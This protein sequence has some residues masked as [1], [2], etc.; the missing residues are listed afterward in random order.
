MKRQSATYLYILLLLHILLPLAVEAQETSYTDS[1]RY[2][3]VGGTGEG[4]SWTDAYG[5]LQ[6][7]INDLHDHLEEG[8]GRIY[9]A[10]GAY[11]PTET[12]EGI[13]SIVNNTRFTSFKIY[14]GITIYG[15]FAADI[16][17]EPGATA[18]TVLNLPNTRIM[19]DGT[20]TSTYAEWKNEKWNFAH[21]T[22]LSGEHS[23]APT[24][25]WDA[26]GGTYNTNLEGCSYHVIWFATNGFI[27]TGETPN[28]VTTNYAKPLKQTSE[29]NGVTIKHG[30]ANGA[31][32]YAH[33]YKGGGVYMVGNS[34]LINCIVSRCEANN[35]GGGIYMDGG[36]Y[37][38]NCFVHTNQALGKETSEDDGTNSY[39]GGICIDYDGTVIR[40]IMTNN[41]AQRGGG[42]AILHE[43]G[44][45][46][47]SNIGESNHKSFLSPSAAG[48]V[49]S[50]NTSIH[51]AGGVL[52]KEGGNINHMTITNNRCN[53]KNLII[54]GRRIGRSGGIYIDKCGVVFNSVCWGNS[55]D[56]NDIQY[57]AYTANST[58][59][60]SPWVYFSAFSRHDL[61]D[62]HGTV[63]DNVLSISPENSNTTV[64]GLYPEF[65][66]PTSVAGVSITDKGEPALC[67]W[68]PHAYS[69][70]RGQG[71][72]L[73]DFITVKDMLAAEIKQDMRSNTFA[74]RTTLGAYFP[75]KDKRQPVEIP[76]VNGSGEN[77]KTLFVDPQRKYKAS[78]NLDDQ[79][80]GDSWDS[81]LGNLNDALNFIEEERKTNSE[82]SEGKWQILVKEGELTT[83]GNYVTGS[84][85]SSSII[86]QSNVSIYGG[87]PKGLTGTNLSSGVLE[88]NPVEY[89]TILTG[90][91]TGHNYNRNAHHLV[92]FNEVSNAILDGFKLYY[93]NAYTE[94][95]N[96]ARS[97]H[98][99]GVIVYSETEGVSMEGNVMRNCVI[100]N[101]TGDEGVAVY[102]TGLNT[103]GEDYPVKFS[104]ENCIVHNNES[105]NSTTKSAI[106]AKGANTTL[107]LNHCTI[108]G[109]IG[110]AV[111]GLESAEVTLN[112]S[113]IHANAS[114]EVTGVNNLDAN[115]VMTV[116]G[117]IAGN[118]NMVDK[119]KD[120]PSGNNNYNTLTYT[121]GDI[122]YPHFIN[123]TNNIGVSTEADNTIYGGTPNFMPG[124]MSPV[125]N[126]ADATDSDK[127]DISVI[128]TR[129]YGGLPD[130]GAVECSELPAYG[131]VLYVTE[132]GSGTKDGSSWSNAIAGNTIYNINGTRIT[133]NNGT[134]ILTTDSRYCGSNG[135]YYFDRNA[136]PYA[137][138][139]NHSKAFW[140]ANPDRG[141][142]ANRNYRYISNT[143]QETYVSGLQYAVEKASSSNG[144]I[145]EVWVGN[146]VYTDWK[147]FVIRDK[148]SVYGGFP[149]SQGGT[150]GM[151]ERKPL[152]SSS[153]PK[154]EMNESLDAQDYETIIQVSPNSP[155][156]ANDGSANFMS[157]TSNMRKYVLYQPDVCLPTLSPNSEWG[158][159][160]TQSNTYR[161]EDSNGITNANYRYVQYEGASW[162]GFTIR[163]GFINGLGNNRDGG[164]GVRMFRGVT[165]KNCIVKDNR[166]NGN[167][168]RG[169]GI[170]CD[171]GD[172]NSSAVINCYVLNNYCTGN[173]DAYG[174]GMYMI[175]GTSYNS[176]FS[177]NYAQ[178]EGGGIFLECAT[179]YNNTIVSNSSNGTGGMH[180]WV[181]NNGRKSKLAVFNC[182]FYDNGNQAV[183]SQNSND[184]EYFYNCYVQT[185]TDLAQG[186]KNKIP[187]NTTYN[188]LYGI[189]TQL[190]N[191]FVDNGYPETLN[192][193]L[194]K[195][196]L[197]IN[198]GW[199]E[200]AGYTLPDTDVD[201]TDRIQDCT[202]DIG[203]Y[204][205]NGAYD[206]TPMLTY[207]D[208]NGES[209]TGGT[210][211]T[212]TTATFFV[213]EEGRGNAS[214]VSPAEAACVQK[215]QKVLDAAG[216]YKYENPTHQVIVKLAG[217]FKAYEGYFPRR[218]TATAVG[219]INADNPRSL[220]LMIPRGVEVWGGYYD[221]YT[222]EDKHGFLEVNRNIINSQTTLTGK[223]SSDGQET[224]VYHV[225][226]FTDNVYDGDGNIE[227]EDDAPKT[228][229]DKVSK[230][231]TTYYR[232]ILDGLFITGG[233][234]DGLNPIDQYGGA[235]RLPDFT[236]VRN[237]IVSGNEASE[238]GGAFY[239]Q[240]EA[241]V[242]GTILEN[243][244]TEG[245]GGAV[246]VEEPVSSIDEDELLENIELGTYSRIYT[247]TIVKNEAKHGGGIYFTTNLRANSVVLWHNTAD[248]QSNIAGQIDPH[249]TE[250]NEVDIDQQPE[251]YPLAFSAVE[252]LRVA[253]VG[254]ISVDPDE[255]KG[256]RFYHTEHDPYYALQHF[257]ILNRSGMPNDS[258]DAL[259]EQH[260]MP[261]ADL[262]GINRTGYNNG[263]IEIGARVYPG[264]L[265]ENDY[266]HILTRIFVVSAS[267]QPDLSLMRALQESDDEIYKQQGSSFAYPMSRLDDALEYIY[268]LRKKKPESANMLF[269]VFISGGEFYPLRTID[270]SISYSRSNTFLVPEGVSIIGG[271]NPKTP[272][273]QEKT[274]E[275]IVINGVTLQPATTQEMRDARIHYDLN[276]NNIIEPW[277]FEQQ[278]ILSGQV[279]NSEKSQNA[280]HVITCIASEGLMGT[281]PNLG[282]FHVEN[283][284]SHWYD[285]YDTND[286]DIEGEDN[287]TA[288]SGHN[289]EEDP[290]GFIATAG[291]TRS[292]QFGAR[293]LLDGL[294]IND[295]Q[296]Y[297]Y[298]SDM[299][300]SRYTYY[301][302][303][304]ICV[305]GNWVTKTININQTTDEYDALVAASEAEYVY[306]TENNGN[307]TLVG[308]RLFNYVPNTGTGKDNP[309]PIGFRNIPLTV[310]NCQFSNN[311]AG[312]GGAIFS[313]GELEIYGCSF[314][315]N[316]SE[317]C[318]DDRDNDGTKEFHYPGRGGAINVSNRL[319]MVNTLFANN[320]ARKG[321]KDTYTH[322]SAEECEC[323][324][325]GAVV[326]GE[327]SRLHIANCNFVRNK[328]RSYPAIFN[329]SSN[330]GWVVDNGNGTFTDYTPTASPSD[331]EESKTDGSTGAYRSAAVRANNPHRVVNS[332][333][334]GNE[335]SEK[336]GTHMTMAFSYERD[337]EGNIVKDE[338]GND[339]YVE[340][341]WF[342]AYD[343]HCGLTPVLP[344]LKDLVDY[345]RMHFHFHEDRIHDKTY[346]RAAYI[347]AL[348]KYNDG[349]KDDNTTRIFGD[350]KVTHNII[351][352]TDNEAH[353]GPNFINPSTVAGIDGHQAD[354]DWMMSRMN[355]L[356][357]N[358][359]SYLNQQTTPNLDGGYDC[360]FVNLDENGEI[361]DE[362][363]SAGNGIYLTIADQTNNAHL[364]ELKL[365]A[366]PIL[367]PYK[368]E[369][370][371]YYP[372]IIDDE[373]GK[374]EQILRISKDPNP[375]HDQAYIDIG[376]YE[377]QHVQLNPSGDEV[378]VLW[379]CEA[380]KQN[381]QVNDGSSWE[382]ATS[383]LQRAI[384]TLL[385]SRN[386]HAKEIRLIEGRYTPI[387]NI[388]NNLGFRI[389]TTSLN[390]GVFYPVDGS[391]AQGIKSLTIRGGYSNL[392]EE[393][394]DYAQYPSQLVASER[395]GISKEHL[396]HLFLIEDARQWKT[397]RQSNNTLHHEGTDEVIPITIEGVTFVNPQAETHE[398]D[399]ATTHENGGAAL[400]YK[401]QNKVVGDETVSLNPASDGSHK[402]TL[403]NCTFML[404]GTD[405]DVPAVTIGGGGGDALIY[406]SVFH[407]NMGA[408]LKAVDTKVVNSTFAL[409]GGHLQLGNTEEKYIV[410]EEQQ[411]YTS[412]LYNS[413]LWRND[414]NVEGEKA[415][416]STLIVNDRTYSFDDVMYNAISFLPVGIDD[417]NLSLSQTNEDVIE[418]PNF[419]NPLLGATTEEEM[420][421]R[422]FSI[423]PSIKLLSRADSIL[424]KKSVYGV[425]DNSVKLTQVT[426]RAYNPRIFGGGLELGAYENMDKL[427]R[428]VYVDPNLAGSDGDGSSWSNS[429]GIGR[430]QNAI[431]AAAI[432]SASNNDKDAYVFVKGKRGN[433]NLNEGI[434]IR[435]GVNVYGSIRPGYTYMA[436]DETVSDDDTDPEDSQIKLYQARVIAERPGM[437]GPST[438]RTI[439]KEIKSDNNSYSAGQRS[440]VDGFQVTN[441]NTQAAPVVDFGNQNE[442]L[443]QIALRNSII[444]GNTVSGEAVP[445]VNLSNG[446]LYN[447]LIYDNDV[448][449]TN[450]SVVSVS[451]QGRMVN[452]TVVS[453]QTGVNAVTVDKTGNK[454]IASVTYNTADKTPAQETTEKDGSGGFTNCN[455][456]TGNPFAPYFQGE[457]TY[458]HDLPAYKTS[459]NNLAYQLHEESENIDKANDNAVSSGDIS[460]IP[461]GL[462][463]FIDYDT[464]LDLLGNPRKLFGVVDRGCFETWNFNGEDIRTVTTDDV[465]TTYKEV[466]DELYP[467]EGSVVYVQEGESLV[468]DAEMSSTF[469]PS[470]LLLRNGA[471]LYGQGANVSLDYA[472]VEKEFDGIYNLISLPYIYNKVYTVTTDYEEGGLSEN[473]STANFYTYDGEKRATSG[474][475]FAEENSACWIENDGTSD[476]V[477]NQGFLIDRSEETEGLAPQSPISTTFRFT[478]FSQEENNYIYTE[479]SGESS[480]QVT[481]KQYNTTDNS[482]NPFEFTRAEDMGWNLIGMPYLVSNFDT[483]ETTLTTTTDDGNGGSTTVTTETYG[484]NIPHLFYSLN[485]NGG[486]ETHQSWTTYGADGTSIT[487]SAG[488]LSLGEAFFTQTATL[489]DKEE[490]TFLRPIYND[491]ITRTA[492]RAL[493]EVI[494][495]AGSDAIVLNPETENE[496]TTRSETLIEYKQGSDGLKLRSL[497]RELPQLYVNTAT[498][499]RLSLL[500]SA[501]T[502]VEIDLGILVPHA[503]EVSFTL[504]CPEAFAEHEA[505]WLKDSRAGTIV[506]LL[507]DNYTLW[508]EKSGLHEGYLTLQ[509]GGPVP[510]LNPDGK[511][512]EGNHIVF[513]HKG[514]LH[515]QR[516]A[517]GD[518]ITVYTSD[519]K[520]IHR[521]TATETTHTLQ[522]SPGLY[523][524]KVNGN[525][526]KAL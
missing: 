360:E 2:V 13:E 486:Y 482:K 130:I 318:F 175:V 123:P 229:K 206:I 331:G 228:L 5:N 216:R 42:L 485:N 241:I 340:Q 87:Y 490:L 26:S 479:T 274:G 283:G 326:A 202:V 160:D 22:I 32:G 261:M 69:V 501:P 444:V 308:I 505:V 139:S 129:D 235:A 324:F 337:K 19:S 60:A 379:V 15:G 137:E 375:S 380:E 102:V 356:V 303:G 392:S 510:Q 293:I 201:F 75:L 376:V 290:D 105:K 403:A 187:T 439:V 491:E 153:I 40:S 254:N 98:G 467:H 312:M 314:T 267:L 225:V 357:D 489:E 478:G 459:N 136:R 255:A 91:I 287:Y 427:L 423:N 34:R 442:T 302:G 96:A 469:T 262:A 296:A 12:I 525:R 521:S 243:N 127:Y 121:K 65:V 426:D 43:K 358:G 441:P 473:A 412:S 497:N 394:Y 507:T 10:A 170:Y 413:V 179:F 38:D 145:K 395:S 116:Y 109:N 90:Y 227:Y 74:P 48:C 493:L 282:G 190:A 83:A 259:V 68:Q 455:A 447:T 515:I 396:K 49:V 138:S 219:D 508:A 51:E 288:Y 50:N 152:L 44:I 54:N 415:D 147:G 11:Y 284:A 28:T 148:V 460:L 182:L 251:D 151:K 117:S 297:E 354:A 488:T 178:A 215:L 367:I 248:Q 146:G 122:D 397:S 483:G 16:T 3:K 477:A 212:T 92:R 124:N 328:A 338:Q 263:K 445:I 184:L 115:N 294:S 309:R 260:Q 142:G 158:N 73:I 154:S 292:A 420:G 347:P 119:D 461:Q 9:V 177:N 273:C 114:I 422:D 404:N 369:E 120:M 57:A 234:A 71:V 59:E 84:L 63:K 370:Y 176:L 277:E 221:D 391:E 93:G 25:N 264:S 500:S 315:Q 511:T 384:E 272:Y 222:D 46:P 196:S 517:P 191:P 334:W 107:Y 238:G 421:Q 506:N 321:A 526:Y 373:T 343:E 236:H 368:E 434:T 286:D 450:G 401:R 339:K 64:D 429:Y 7:A 161:Y 383:D 162:D 143:R 327:H 256:V 390:D 181:D 349:E 18:E 440:I 319:Y 503:G 378:D 208:E 205:Y 465:T 35:R 484:M 435:R 126:M 56:N 335:I 149:I 382:R 419:R 348:F 454:V 402:L 199:N 342:C 157:N 101:C 476:F 33:T 512:E 305:D 398:E 316:Y 332:I 174:G 492:T 487:T 362:G 100:A 496:N 502:G 452:C 29:L 317:S 310:M 214:A 471:S 409:N 106:A 474:Y 220:S 253:G 165:L 53:G 498:G 173:S 280:F 250:G 233:R 247:S 524:V 67:D 103:E 438:L 210:D 301:K 400:Y 207:T 27:T 291:G 269:E 94:E 203:A 159:S 82:E 341:L 164:A 306:R 330:K 285:Q 213:T 193:R 204:E 41:V 311:S 516:L 443:S 462:A 374:H 185:K 364:I 352:N 365:E 85:R 381:N 58:T 8:T 61:T 433:E 125:V 200:P 14:E 520:I 20:Q 37:V 198:A 481:L 424:Y 389:S 141:T 472:A 351:L 111:A 275:E 361:T 405:A 320:E 377:Y 72:K 4:K 186:I 104:M 430:L 386:G 237:C 144:V 457:G 388:A 406:N 81:P 47:L 366:L 231:N 76:D 266:D 192:F 307:K 166:Y 432:Y 134:D 180:H 304:A 414:L 211:A 268:N 518:E 252:N 217:G 167:R 224:S 242:S 279:I 359:W 17:D 232:S 24:F 466:S 36:G 355:N 95:I 30:Y 371:M 295:G 239:M 62:W 313:N 258:Y 209:L 333:F 458:Q 195:G 270:D 172:G 140:T 188:N 99:A 410:G 249:S 97:K 21:E 150:P 350:P 230:E 289:W 437:A 155:T 446:L 86:M 453:G 189:G 156:K 194:K 6:T 325:G 88:R 436:S 278:T 322:D 353:D 448:N 80:V 470:Y 499:K 344:D 468:L 281:L 475:S 223:Y 408:P 418:G 79:Y 218:T 66:N 514:R 299:I 78:I 428:V 519:G 456:L 133:N 197:C 523:L 240:P 112:N 132:N 345:R 451:G 363:G 131:T 494:N 407:S 183:G 39:G 393:K 522:V 113:I 45:Y 163:H 276:N 226:T 449:E 52:L 411:S 300:G 135:N 244:I 346:S 431:D 464:D 89:P 23:N 168:S 31:E 509:I 118:Y 480:K 108:R 425:T 55:V 416:Y 399:G 323:G 417:S 257:S 110:Y 169:G 245:Y 513:V 271:M 77:I 329:Y 171:D 504:P 463:S 246:F 495:E 336:E 265:R 70:L 128:T 387:Y 385:S 372:Y 298:Q 1:I